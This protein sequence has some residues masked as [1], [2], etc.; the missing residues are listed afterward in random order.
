MEHSHT[1]TG[2]RGTER[3]GLRNE[4]GHAFCA[5]PYRD[6]MGKHGSLHSLLFHFIGDFVE[7]LRSFVADVVNFF[8]AGIQGVFARVS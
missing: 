7:G 6:L 1:C 3:R 8:G 4:K 2:A 5:W